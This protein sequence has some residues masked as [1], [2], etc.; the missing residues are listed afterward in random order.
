MYDQESFIK[1]LKRGGRSATAIDRVLRISDSFTLSLANNESNLNNCDQD[2]LD[3]FLLQYPL[4]RSKTILWALIY[5]FDFTNRQGLRSVASNMRQARIKR[6]PFPLRQFRGIDN[7]TVD[8]LISLEL[9]TAP[10]FLKASATQEKRIALAQK[11]GIPVGT[12]LRIARMCDLARIP[13]IKSIRAPL[14]L[15]AGIRGIAGLAQ[16]DA[17]ELRQHMVQHVEQT[18]FDGIAPLPAEIRYSI[19]KAQELP[20]ILE[21]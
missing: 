15:A 20:A 19:A 14:Y 8:K 12:L 21:F 16:W 1:Y 3:E 17:D 7:D 10:A 18:G 11:S 9:S 4:E 6:K 13:G 5:L 2:D